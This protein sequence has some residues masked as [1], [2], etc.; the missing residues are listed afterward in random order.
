[1]FQKFMTKLF[2]PSEQE[3]AQEVDAEMQQKERIQ[4][5]FIEDLQ[6]IFTQAEGPH[7]ET[8]TEKWYSFDSAR[9]QLLR[10]CQIFIS[11]HRL[12]MNS[13]NPETATRNK[14]LAIEIWMSGFD[15]RPALRNTLGIYLQQEVVDDLDINLKR[16]FNQYEWRILLHEA[17][18]LLDKAEKLKTA[19][20]RAKYLTSVAKIVGQVRIM[21]DVDAE[22]LQ[23]TIDRCEK[24]KEQV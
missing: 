15:N 13:K 23:G 20:G 16:Q 2:G 24:L 9:G 11:C 18:G 5:I 12:A 10:E 17:N 3:L 8:I 1:M 4:E 6:V 22:D 19:K 21:G 7:W 14:K